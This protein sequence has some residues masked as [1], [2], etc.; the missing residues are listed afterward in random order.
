[1]S[2]KEEQSLEEVRR[3]QILEAAEVVFAERGIDKA[4][5]DD[6]GEKTGL[7]KGTLY[8][9]F[10]SKEAIVD[11][12]I[13]RYFGGELQRA[14]E[15]LQAEGHAM[16]RAEQFLTIAIQE[17]RRMERL[18]P[19]GYEIFSLVARQKHVR[20][21]LQ[22]YYHQY[23][24]LLADILEQGMERGEIRELDSQEAAL[25][26]GGLIEGIALYWFIDPQSVDWNRMEKT[27]FSIL[28]Q[29]LKRPER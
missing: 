17:I 25:A 4:R 6:I 21:R 8:W 12:I 9:Y 16:E 13:D 5:M 19:L 29:G 28:E 27:A 23:I 22:G 11:A 20:Q 24:Q 3:S 7:A 1:M 2:Q 10:K 26:V 15:L 18:M 14:Q